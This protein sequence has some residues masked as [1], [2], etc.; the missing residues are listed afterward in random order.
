MNTFT[1]ASPTEHPVTPEQIMAMLDRELPAEE[2]T[3]VFEHVR[4]C[5]DCAQIAVQL[6]DL[7]RELSAW[8]V[9]ALSPS[10]EERVLSA[11]AGQGPKGPRFEFR[12]PGRPRFA[13]L[14]PRWAIGLG[15]AAVVFVVFLAMRQERMARHSVAAPETMYTLNGGSPAAGSAGGGTA[16]R[17][18]QVEEFLKAQKQNLNRETE[19]YQRALQARQQEQLSSSLAN[20]EANDPRVSK[21]VTLNQPGVA[22]DSNGNFHGLGDHA[23]NSIEVDG[24]PGDE[25]VD[26]HQPMIARSVSVSLIAKDFQSARTSLDALLAKHH[27]YAAQLSANTSENSPRSITASL[28]IPANRLA[29]AL[30]DLRAIGHVES[31]SQ[32]GEEVT[33]QHA[34]LAARLKNSR[35][36]ELRLQAILQQRTGKIADVLEVEREIARVRGEI[37]QMDA[38]QKSLEH[39]VDFVSIDVQIAEEYKAQIGTSLPSSATRMRN[40]AIS[41]YHHATETLLG[42]ALFFFESGPTLL[43]W[44]ALLAIPGYWLLRRYRRAFAST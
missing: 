16:V 1:P 11:A 25:A 3:A 40:A 26:I 34:D 5:A 29:A 37:E 2:A 27:G 4:H 43:I 30:A 32:A 24:Q 28:R 39:R 10:A 23:S 41:G 21:L 19:A 44:L 38:E 9:E 14:R 20:N 33:Q 42:F 13:F 22:A 12:I 17:S 18:Q 7:G 31:E 15:A 8:R 6:G 35:E 36:T